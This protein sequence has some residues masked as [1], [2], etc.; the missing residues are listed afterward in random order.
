MLRPSFTVDALEQPVEFEREGVRW[1]FRIDRIDT[2]AAGGRV[3]IDYKTGEVST[4]KIYGVP[5]ESP[6][7]ALYV[8]ALKD[9]T[10]VNSVEAVVLAQ[11]KT[12][13]VKAEGIGESG[14]GF[15]DLKSLAN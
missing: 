14:V 4:S 7:L 12:N 5:L 2:L 15:P 10:G 9:Q 13:D 11:L 1:T 8:H 6:Q 3:V